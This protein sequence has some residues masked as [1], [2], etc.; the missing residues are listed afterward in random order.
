MGIGERAANMHTH[1]ACLNRLRGRACTCHGQHGA[2]QAPPPTHTTN[3]R[4][5]S[6]KMIE[7][8][9]FGKNKVMM[10]QQ[11]SKERPHSPEIVPVKS[12][13]EQPKSKAF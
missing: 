3:Q 12:Q 7:V 11:L 4:T 9:S 6:G 13:L 1:Q 8:S 10:H 2:T 5:V